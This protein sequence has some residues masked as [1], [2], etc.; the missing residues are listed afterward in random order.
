LKLLFCEG[1]ALLAQNRSGLALVPMALCP[2]CGIR[3]ADTVEDI[4][5]TKIR[6][7]S[8]QAGYAWPKHLL[9]CCSECNGRLNKYV[10]EPA[11]GLVESMIF[12]RPPDFRMYDESDCRILARWIFKQVVLKSIQQHD[13]DVPASFYRW[14]NKTGYSSAIPAGTSFWVGYA[15]PDAAPMTPAERHLF[16]QAPYPTMKWNYVAEVGNLFMLVLYGTTQRGWEITNRALQQGYVVPLHF[17]AG[18]EM[19]WPSTKPIS[20]SI[21]DAITEA[22]P[23]IVAT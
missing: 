22:F 18:S 17:G 2:I 10:E 15:T 1:I 12:D 11:W 14:L 21:R 19:G 4:L 7:R 6:T 13:T 8:R 23:V 20:E 16:S 9:E 3:D 5:P